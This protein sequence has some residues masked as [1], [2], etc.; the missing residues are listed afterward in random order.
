M[1][2]NRLGTLI[3]FV[4]TV[5]FP[6]ISQ[7]PFFLNILI[8]TGIWAIAVWGVR[9]VMSTGQM[10]LGHAA[11]MAVG[12]YASSLLV[13]KAGLSFWLALPLSGLTAALVALMIGLPTLRIKGVYFSIITFAFAEII[14]LIIINWPNF[15]GGSGGIPGIPSPEPL[16]SIPFTNRVAF[17][18]LVLFISV[19][20]Y[21]V[22]WAIE[23][24]RIGK[25]FSAI[26]EGDDLA[27]SVGVNLMKYKLIAFCIGCFF[28]GLSGSIYA[29]YFNFASPEFFT[30]W[31]SVYCL[32]FVIVGGV[33]HVL[34]PLVGSFFMTL[35]PELLRKTKE[36][37]PVVYALILI[38][39]MFLLP[40]G[41]I[42][43]PV[44][45]K[46]KIFG[47]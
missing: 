28:A 46:T 32:L 39:V 12:A 13:M 2:K 18:Y 25:I 22:M 11:Y 27:Q 24:S 7:D 33:G 41:L 44:R 8:T 5:L 21:S 10:T 42:S 45:L 1:L 31:Q 4:A 20:T 34:G 14:R 19:I 15:L 37:E 17:Y 36:Y 38:L 3:L 6:L 35:V 43:L 40:G 26:H 30:I 23:K 16:F 9:L 29:H 47:R